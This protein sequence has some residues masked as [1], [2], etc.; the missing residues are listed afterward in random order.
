MEGGRLLTDGALVVTGAVAVD[1]V[2]DDVY[3]GG[4][5]VELRHERLV[6]VGDALAEPEALGPPEVAPIQL[7]P[8]VQVAQQRQELLDRDAFATLGVNA[9]DPVGAPRGEA[10]EALD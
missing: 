10:V 5:G 9:A 2:G 7:V 8:G 1:D 4:P 6:L 3:G